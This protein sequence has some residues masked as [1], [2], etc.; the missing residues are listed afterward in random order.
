MEKKPHKN[1][2]FLQIIPRSLSPINH[3]RRPLS[4]SL[5]NFLTPTP[6]L[7]YYIYI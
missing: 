5:L 1:L 3:K 7:L 2:F 4:R 6:F